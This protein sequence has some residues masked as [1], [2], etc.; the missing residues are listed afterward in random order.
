MKVEEVFRSRI[1]IFI[2]QIL[3]LTL[4]ILFM[5]YRIDINFDGGILEEQKAIIQ[6]LANYV[7]FDKL[8]G[9]YFIYFVWIIVS[10]IPIFIY[11]DFKKSY[12]MNLMVFF[13]PNFFLYIFLSRYSPIYFNSNFQFH[14]LHTILLCIVIVLISIGIPL[15][16]RK[17]KKFIS[18]T[19]IEDLHAIASKSKKICPICGTEYESSPKFCYKCNTD[20]TIPIEDK[21]RKEE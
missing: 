18:E 3:I 20:L 2:F 17:I 5:D 15:I 11:N 16:L 10:L 9:L 12:S 21:I 6:F 7:L 13:F 4:F 19:P 1:V 8:S 14:F